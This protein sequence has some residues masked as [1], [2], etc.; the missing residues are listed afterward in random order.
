MRITSKWFPVS[1]ISTWI[2][3]CFTGLNVR[4]G[5]CEIQVFSWAP[6][7]TTKKYFFFLANSVI[8]FVYSV[9]YR[10]SMLFILV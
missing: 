7:S 9:S 6:P 10:L 4:M 8:S 2:G 1:C 3:L 5:F